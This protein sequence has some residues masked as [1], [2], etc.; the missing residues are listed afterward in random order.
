MK[1]I[2]FSSNNFKNKPKPVIVTELISNDSL[3]DI[4]ELERNSCCHP[5][6]MTLKNRSIFSELHQA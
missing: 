3:K 4:I 1:F 2:G 6:G 5:I